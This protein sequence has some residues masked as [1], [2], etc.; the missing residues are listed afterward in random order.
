MVAVAGWEPQS[1]SS[2][3]SASRRTIRVALA[4]FSWP[5]DPAFAVGRD[6]TTLARALFATPVRV[7]RDG[8]LVPGLCSSWR[9]DRSFRT[10]RF[11]CRSARA[12]AAGLRRVA[13]LQ[14]A[15]A[16]WLFAAERIVASSRSSLLIRLRFPWRR[17]PFALTAVAAAPRGVPG[18]FRLLR[19]SPQR[20]IARRG[21]TTL[22]FRR[23]GGIAAVRAFRRGEVDEAPVPTGDIGSGLGD[24]LRVR[25]LLGLDLVVTTPRSVLAHRPALREAYWQTANRGDYEALV[26][27]RRAPAAFSLFGGGRQDPAR[28]RRALR[29]IPT[30]PRVRVRFSASPR[31][32]YGGGLLYGQW[33]EAGLGPVMVPAGAPADARLER[34]IAPYPQPEA[35]A[36]ALVLGD[37]PGRSD[38]RE[39]VARMSQRAAL[40]RVDA[41]LRRSAVVI[42]IASVA[43][44]RLVSPRLSGWR[45]TPLGD[46]DY[47]RVFARDGF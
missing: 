40:G 41:A 13:G 17:F 9:A 21:E 27:E 43:D 36:A 20:V 11:T 28:F 15:P 7:G 4:D 31:L 18:P 1:A 6:E 42:P 23:L 29:S 30:L 46:V 38:L 2:A 35:L 32:T 37:R 16:G 8:A 47:T 10:W 24:A 45:E 3:A 19:G 14:K 25:R 34:L 22:E 33:R 26:S 5:L 44:A 39:A 12:I